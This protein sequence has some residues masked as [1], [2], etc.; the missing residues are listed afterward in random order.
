MC[1]RDRDNIL[2]EGAQATIEEYNYDECVRMANAMA[3]KTENGIMV[4]DTAWDGYEE[5]PA[6]IMQGYG[7][8]AMEADEQLHT[9]GCD[10]PTHVFIQAGVGSLAGAVQGL[11]LIH[12]FPSKSY[13]T[14][15]LNWKPS[16]LPKANSLDNTFRRNHA[17]IYSSIASDT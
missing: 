14:L 11:S 1:I 4:Q 10:R 16:I 12:I 13:P 5:I 3:E 6:W 9:A 8:M 7:T 2:A 17:L 15:M